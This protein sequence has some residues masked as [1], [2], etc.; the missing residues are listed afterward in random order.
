MID[1]MR[2]LKSLSMITFMDVIRDKI[3]YSALLVAFLLL[4]TGY[5]AS[6]LTFIRPE[7][8]VLNFG[9]T[10]VVLTSVFVGIFVSASLLGREIEK[11]TLH[12]VLSR[13]V[14]RT[15]FLFGKY[16]GFIGVLAANWLLITL[17]FLYILSVVGGSI[18]TTLLIALFFAFL[19]GAYAG[20]ITLFFSCFSTTTL[21]VILSLGVFF[22]GSECLSAK[23]LGT[24][25]PQ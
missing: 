13:P 16:I 22:G 6:G 23:V 20:A 17:S 24:D 25:C 7:R 15:V 18:S 14:H 8:I 1:L 11:R 4:G 19:Q 21:S 12:V 2:T 10:T 5:L 9:L 3:L